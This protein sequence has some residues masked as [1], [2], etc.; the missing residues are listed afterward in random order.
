M[1]YLGLAVIRNR[2]LDLSIPGHVYTLLQLLD[3]LVY[4]VVVDILMVWLFLPFSSSLLI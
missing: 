4:V 2:S 1:Q 3:K